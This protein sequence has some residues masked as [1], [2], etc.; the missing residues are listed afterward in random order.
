MSAR[1]HPPNL[2]RLATALRRG[3][4]VAIPNVHDGDTCEL[5]VESTTLQ[6]DR[7]GHLSGVPGP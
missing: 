5:G 1:I 4:L 7:S 3:A 6:S 2:R